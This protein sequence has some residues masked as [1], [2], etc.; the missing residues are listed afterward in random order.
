MT[1]TGET[2]RIALLALLAGVALPIAV[3]LYLTL[4]STAGV[5]RQLDRRLD[6]AFDDLARATAS[7]RQ[8][9]GASSATSAV[10]AAL[11]PAVV[12]GV[13]AFRTTATP[14]DGVPSQ[15]HEAPAKEKT[16]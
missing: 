10:L 5:V 9:A 14:L 2:I 4:R 1:S 8:G 7:V 16:S 12:A 6:R 3:Q 11:G 13:R 15:A